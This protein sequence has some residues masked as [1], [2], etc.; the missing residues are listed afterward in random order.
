MKFRTEVNL[1]DSA[2]KIGIEDKIFSIGSCFATEISDLLAKGQLQTLNN[3]FGTVFN[4]FSINNAV[5]RLHDS[6]FYT[7]EELIAYDE[8]FI[9]LDHH[10]SFDTRFVHQTLAKINNQ[11]EKGNRFL[12]TTSWV[13]V[14]YGTSFIYE[15]L[16]KQ[17]LVGN[18]HKIPQKYF[19][20]RLLTHHEIVNSIEETILNLKDICNE[21]VQILF[22]VSPVRHTKDGMV[23]NML[24]KSKLISALHEVI[25]SFENCTYLPV[26]EILMDDLRDYRFYKDDL[27]HP[28]SQAV[29]YIFEKLAE[30]YFTDDTKNFIQ[31]NFKIS[32]AL[33]HRSDNEKDPKHLVFMKKIEENIKNQ[34][35]KVKHKIFS[36]E[37]F[38]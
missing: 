32:Q 7:E 14:T 38:S 36:D 28:N 20:K 16:P 21:N 23:E 19:K 34:Q 17:Q 8:K 29:Q 33:L 37:R 24:S 15:F 22:T 13:I 11:I 5:K 1:P 31:E 18:C 26:Y 9:S 35:G 27:I 4:P 2:I 25:N 10:T 30:A 3:S 6:D 12:Q